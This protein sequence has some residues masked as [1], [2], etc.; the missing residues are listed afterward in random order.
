M[1]NEADSV[2]VSAFVKRDGR[3]SMGEGLDGDG[4]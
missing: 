2:I 3:E 1:D 4:L